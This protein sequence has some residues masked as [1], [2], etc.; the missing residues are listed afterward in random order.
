MMFIDDFGCV[1]LTEIFC[2]PMLDATTKKYAAMLLR[3]ICNAGAR[4]D[5][6]ETD[7]RRRQRQKETFAL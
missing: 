2:Q 7:F 3:T 6:T 4:D 5:V 1:T